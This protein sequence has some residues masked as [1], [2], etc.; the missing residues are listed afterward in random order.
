MAPFVLHVDLDQFIAAVEVLRR[1]ELR[2]RPVVVGGGGDP[3]RRGVVSTASYEAR[4]FGIASGMALRTAARRCPEAVF[5]PV[6]RSAYQAASEKVMETLRAFPAVVEVAGWDEAF[7]AGD[8]DDPERLAGEIQKAV[9]ERTELSCSVGI[10]DNKLQAKVASNLAKPGGV[11]RL[12]RAT[13]RAA[14]D[15]R[16]PDALWGIGRKR[17]RRLAALGIPTVGALAGA[18]GAVLAEAFGPGLGPWLVTI[19]RGE[20]DSPVLAEPYPAKS[21]GR[22]TTFEEDLEDPQ[23][24]RRQVRRLAGEVAED[25]AREGRGASRMI[26]K[27]RFAPFET[28]T[29]GVALEV[30]ALDAGALE[31]AALRALEW[32]EIDRPVRL[33]GVRADLAP[34]RPG[35]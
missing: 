26:V 25:V 7:V 13:W 8:T 12:S 14:M 24:V 19:A 11:V 33:L 16:P 2:G 29:H 28:H 9:A 4:R 34:P 18:D 21:R 30:P 15:D 35:A 22:E 23:Q 20:D 10:G 27:V 32:F 3:T 17:A 5:L 31:E 6:D 1:P